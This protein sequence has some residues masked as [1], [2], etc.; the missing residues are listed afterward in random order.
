MRKADCKTPEDFA[1]YERYRAAIRSWQENNP[2]KIR[3]YGKAQRDRTSKDVLAARVKASKLKKADDYLKRGREYAR[4][5]RAQMTAQEL[6]QFKEHQRETG[7]AWRAKMKAGDPERYAAY[8]ARLRRSYRKYAANPNNRTK[9]NARSN[10]YRAEHLE[11]YRVHAVTRAHRV[12]GGGPIDRGYVAWLRMQPCLD[13]GS[14]ERIEVG[15]LIPV[16]NGGSNSRQNLIAHCRSCNRRMNRKVHPRA[17]M[18][19]YPEALAAGA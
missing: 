5:K 11:A 15:H 13:C 18:V 2:E 6:A 17:M 19:N 12:R 1:R 7:R 14:T 16:V 4:A 3:E 8:L 9:L 10:A